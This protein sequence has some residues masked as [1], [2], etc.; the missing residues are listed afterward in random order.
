MHATILAAARR[1]ALPRPGG[2]FQPPGLAGAGDDGP[3]SFGLDH[4]AAH[5]FRHPRPMRI[6]KDAGFA[7]VASSGLLPAWAEPKLYRSPSF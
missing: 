6:S 3:A 7:L 2:H 5:G 1:L 4:A